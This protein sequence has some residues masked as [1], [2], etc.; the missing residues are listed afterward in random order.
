MQ[1]KFPGL[2]NK[3]RECLCRGD[4][5]DRVQFMLHSNKFSMEGKTCVVHKAA[6]QE[7]C[8]AQVLFDYPQVRPQEPGPLYF[9]QSGAPLTSALLSKYLKEALQA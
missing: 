8:P 6:T 5:D 7:L 9:L 1:I 3:N 4:P 2:H